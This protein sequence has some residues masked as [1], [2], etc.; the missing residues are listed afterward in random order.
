[1]VPDPSPRRADPLAFSSPG[2]GLSGQGASLIDGAARR[3]L[4]LLSR[5][6]DSLSDRPGWFLLKA[7]AH[8][9]LGMYGQ[10]AACLDLGLAKFPDHPALNILSW[11]VMTA[12][13][14]PDGAARACEALLARCPVILSCSRRDSGSC[15]GW[16]NRPETGHRHRTRRR[17]MHWTSSTGCSSGWMTPPTTRCC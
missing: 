1:M 4:S 11:R 7:R 12:Q 15:R 17:P 10:A 6:G 5:H 14:D 3:A 8:A 2:P 13:E 9:D 16:T